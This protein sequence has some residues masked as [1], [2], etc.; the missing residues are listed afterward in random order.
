MERMIMYKWVFRMHKKHQK[1]WIATDTA[2]CQWNTVE[3]VVCMTM[4][5]VISYRNS[6]TLVHLSF[7]IQ[8]SRYLISSAVYDWHGKEITPKYTEFWHSFYG[9]IILK[10][11]HLRGN[12]KSKKTYLE[13]I[14]DA[15]HNLIKFCDFRVLR[16]L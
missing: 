16:R 15:L 7:W 8:R 10:K 6:D 4:L 2:E 14:S 5:R 1:G 12:G 9:H 11:W 13:F 3:T